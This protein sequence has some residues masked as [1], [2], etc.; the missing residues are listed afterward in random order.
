M[1]TIVNALAGGRK[2]GTESKMLFAIHCL[3]AKGAAARR[4]KYYAEHRAHQDNGAAFGVNVVMGG[5]LVADDGQ[6]AVGSL[7]V[8]D[9]PDRAAAEAFNRADPFRRNGVWDRV[10]VNAYLKR[11][12]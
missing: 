5:P 3:D 2:P 8:V 1:R 6:T 4:E 10:D 9:A 12:G 11:R 7:I